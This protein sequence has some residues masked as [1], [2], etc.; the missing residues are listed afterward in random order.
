MHQKISRIRQFE[1][2]LYE[3]FHDI[4]AIW[5]FLHFWVFSQLFEETNLRAIQFSQ[6]ETL[7][8]SPVIF[9][10]I[11][12]HVIT[13]YSILTLECLR[14]TWPHR[15]FYG[16]IYTYWIIPWLMKFL[17]LFYVSKSRYNGSFKPKI[18]FISYNTLPLLK[19]FSKS[20]LFVTKNSSPLMLWYKPCMLQYP[21]LSFG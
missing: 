8:T 1:L 18:Y 19:P 20:Y 17:C 5:Y 2:F 4:Y 7:K 6:K 13:L 10:C 21:L 3:F 14:N 9:H 15:C 11:W 12:N 16:Y